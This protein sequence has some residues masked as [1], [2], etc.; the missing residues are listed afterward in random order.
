MKT[1]ELITRTDIDG[2]WFIVRLSDENGKKIDEKFYSDE[3][4]ANEVF[5]AA[6]EN[7]NHLGQEEVMRKEEFNDDVRRVWISLNDGCCV[8]KSPENAVDSFVSIETDAP[9]EIVE[10]AMAENRGVVRDVVGYLRH[11]NFAVIK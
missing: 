5:L 10:R 2:K 8:E 1:L 11:I 3:F 4:K 7:F 6:K 9:T